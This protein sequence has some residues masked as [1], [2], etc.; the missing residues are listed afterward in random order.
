MNYFTYNRYRL[1]A[2]YI[3]QKVKWYT[4][5]T[6]AFLFYNRSSFDQELNFPETSG[7]GTYVSSI[8]TFSLDRSNNLKAGLHFTYS[9]KVQDLLYENAAFSRMD[10]FLRY[11]FLKNKLVL[12]ARAGDIFKTSKISKSTSTSNIYQIYSNYND[13]RSFRLSISY[14]FGNSK[15][16]SSRSRSG[17]CK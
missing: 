11:G 6:E 17:S 16:K 1:S 14:N 9:S 15:I 4:F 12:S 5:D 3:F 10:L 7:W 13:N 8:H 2:G